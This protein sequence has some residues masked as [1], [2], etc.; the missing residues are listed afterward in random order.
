MQLVDARL[1]QD[2]VSW[3]SKA[4]WMKAF[5]PDLSDLIFCCSD[6]AHGWSQLCFSSCGLGGSVQEQQAFLA[7]YMASTLDLLAP[8]GWHATSAK[9]SPCST[10]FAS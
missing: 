7:N 3:N 9:A 6:A 8:L 1:A 5:K 2:K 10:E 4:R